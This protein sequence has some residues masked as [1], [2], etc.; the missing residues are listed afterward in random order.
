VRRIVRVLLIV[1]ATALC[2]TP[3]VAHA[4]TGRA[5]FDIASVGDSTFTFNI[6]GSPW[7]SK[8]QQG[9]AVDPAHGDELIA[10]FR[11]IGV[12]GG[13]ATALVTGQTARLSSTYAAILKEPRPAFYR[14]PLFWIGAFAGGVVG[15][16]LHAH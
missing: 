11:V 16:I 6:G 4:Q 15:F 13:V 14:E 1:V 2:V 8:G 10:R 5:R 12:T 9:L 7:V 3:A